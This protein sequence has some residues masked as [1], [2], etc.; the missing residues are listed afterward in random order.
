M[1]T[2]KVLITGAN[3]QLGQCLQQI[4]GSYTNYEFVFA[5]RTT[6]PLDI[7]SQMAA[8]INE[9]QPDII[10]NTA[11]YTAVDKA[12]SEPEL[13]F[14]INADAIGFLGKLAA[15]KSIRLIHISTD[16]VFNG[17]GQSPYLE[18]H[19]TA[20]INVYGASKLKG[21]QSLLTA[22][23]K[24]C[25]IR[26]SWVYS[27]FGNNFVKTMLR[28]LTSKE[29]I[30][31]VSDQIGSPT[32]A[33]DLA[34]VIMAMCGHEDISGIYHFAN[35]GIITWYDFAKAIGEEINSSCVINPIPSKDY[36]TP[37]RRPHYSAMDT[38]KIATKL[39][40]EIP[41]WLSS[42]KSTLTILQP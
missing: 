25:I 4:S 31:V 24:A 8:Y 39:N 15:E 23:P 5:D 32:N 17:E 19:P 1:T 13:A 11:A 29:S 20:P 22:N 26:T 12:E 9:I 18:N 33:I 36:P 14:A 42:L 7:Q 37:A 38:G 41:N 35:S 16:Y 28:L 27:Q 3:G 21:E 34:N 10:I 6:M 2:K 40:L 30:N